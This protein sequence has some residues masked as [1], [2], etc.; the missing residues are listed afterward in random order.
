MRNKDVLKKL[1]NL[2][3]NTKEY[4]DTNELVKV[5]TDFE[6]TST[7]KVAMVYTDSLTAGRRY[8]FPF[9]VYPNIA[10]AAIVKKYEDGTTKNI[11]TMKKSTDY[12]YIAAMYK[13]F[14]VYHRS[15]YGTMSRI[16]GTFGTTSSEYT[17]TFTKVVLDTISDSTVFEPIKDY[18]P[19]TKKYVDDNKVI[20]P[21]NISEFTNDSKYINQI[22]VLPVE[23]DNDKMVNVQN[24]DPHSIY[25]VP[26]DIDY[27]DLGCMGESNRL[28]TVLATP[29]TEEFIY[30]GNKTDKY[31]SFRF[32]ARTHTIYFKTDTESSRIERYPYYLTPSNN[33]AYTPKNDYNPT[34][35]K[36]V[37]DKV[38]GIVNSA[39]ETLD[40]LQELATALGNDANFATTVSTQIGKKVD[41]VDGMSLTHNDLTN[42][43]K[44]NYDAAYK[45]SQAKHSYNDLTDKPTIPSI[46][47]LATTEYVDSKS[48]PIL[49]LDD[50]NRTG[51]KLFPLL[52][53]H[54]LVFL[55]GDAQFTDENGNINIIYGLC[56]S[57]LQSDGSKLL[58]EYRTSKSASISANGTLKS[59]D[60]IDEYTKTIL[61]LFKNAPSGKVLVKNKNN[62]FEWVELPSSSDLSS[63]A[64]IT[65][66]VFK[67]SIRIGDVDP[68]KTLGENSIIVSSYGEASGIYTLSNGK[69][70]AARAN[71]SH[72]EGYASM[73]KGI[74]SHA[75]GEQTGAEGQASHSEGNGATAKGI[76]SH[77]EGYYTTSNGK[78]SHAEGYKTIA[79]GDNQHVQGKYNIEDKANKYAHIVGNGYRDELNYV[80]YRSNAYTLDWSGNGWFAGKVTQ[81]GT[82]TND[83]DLVN[84]KYV[85]DKT[86]MENVIY[87]GNGTGPDAISD[88][89]TDCPVSKG[90]G[91]WVI[92]KQIE[93]DSSKPNPYYLLCDNT[94]YSPENS[95]FDKTNSAWIYPKVPNTGTIFICNKYNG[96]NKLVLPW[97]DVNTPG[98]IKLYTKTELAAAI[99]DGDLEATSD[100][101]KA[102]LANVL[103]GDYSG[104]KN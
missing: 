54:N 72:A 66:P 26:S 7:G 95:T 43:L 48:L 49:F 104:K 15:A 32:G 63:Y 68:E 23:Y 64:P 88:Y 75:E 100:E 69:A 93:F 29:N 70:A 86:S 21:T 99:S 27:L 50:S 14:D 90:N 2:P 56:Y 9:E 85:D 60:Y 46:A 44:A 36:Y 12:V 62:T 55:A 13:T 67:K 74:Y 96:E 78:Y 17:S 6:I 89:W 4:I 5:I 25:V 84:K 101:V 35:K 76:A 22:K 91:C 97:D 57:D 42:E 34:T 38:A 71:Y 19:A 41:K 51:D 45:Y 87:E 31:I 52:P 37:D 103:G 61:T 102:M 83:K 98:K 80:D 1:K 73:T 39:P 53:E 59:F 3:D 47:G 20:V 81:E 11:T 77:A 10:S 28:V 92:N 94:L 24:L 33:E 58:T 40:T 30:T 8:R 65:S 79:T 82:P 18:H 16:N